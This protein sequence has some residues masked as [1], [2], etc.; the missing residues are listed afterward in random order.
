MTVT[1]SASCTATND[2]TLLRICQPQPRLSKEPQ[3]TVTP[4][5]L[6]EALLEEHGSRS[7]AHYNCTI[8]A[9]LPA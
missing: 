5:A 3:L 8:E 9:K 1:S 6:R 7:F 4:E 2:L